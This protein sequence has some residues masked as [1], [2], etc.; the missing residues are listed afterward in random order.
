M[1][2]SKLAAC[3]LKRDGLSVWL[4]QSRLFCICK[5]HYLVSRWIESFQRHQDPK[6]QYYNDL[7]FGEAYQVFINFVEIVLCEVAGDL[8]QASIYS[9]FFFATRAASGSE[10]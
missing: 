9:S 4:R 6:I 3:L 10:I 7:F 5:Y 1:V 2:C 8:S